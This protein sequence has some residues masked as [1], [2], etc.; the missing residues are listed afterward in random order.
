MYPASASLHTLNN[1][2]CFNS[3]KMSNS[4]AWSF[5][6]VFGCSAFSDAFAEF[7]VGIITILSDLTFVAI[8]SSS[9]FQKLGDAAESMTAVPHLLCQLASFCIHFLRTLDI[10]FDTLSVFPRSTFLFLCSTLLGGAIFLYVKLPFRLFTTPG[11][12]CSFSSC[13]PAN[14]QL[15]SADF[16]L[17]DRLCVLL[18]SSKQF[19]SL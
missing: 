6:F 13:G 16:H 14:Y 4:L 5:N 18:S 3:S 15:G 17:A 11:F 9:S 7:P 12:H 1:E 19:S 10:M 8:C 2:L